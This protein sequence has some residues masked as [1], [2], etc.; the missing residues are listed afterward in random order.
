MNTQN[1]SMLVGI[2]VLGKKSGAAICLSIRYSVSPGMVDLINL[3]RNM[4]ERK[5]ASDGLAPQLI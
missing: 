5:M 2:P 1:S 4:S 3:C